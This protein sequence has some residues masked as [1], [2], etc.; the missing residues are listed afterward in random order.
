MYCTLNGCFD[1]ESFEIGFGSEQTFHLILD[2]ISIFF[3]GNREISKRIAF[4]VYL[5]IDNEINKKE[6]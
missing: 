2:Q 4:S 6:N 1:F 5:E 3:L